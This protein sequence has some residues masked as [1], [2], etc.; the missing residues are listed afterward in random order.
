MGGGTKGIHTKWEGLVSHGV[1]MILRLFLGDW[2]LDV[3]LRIFPLDG[4]IKSAHGDSLSTLGNS[5]DH[6]VA[7]IE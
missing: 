6:D 1:N 5:G 2:S 7:G 4:A 3:A